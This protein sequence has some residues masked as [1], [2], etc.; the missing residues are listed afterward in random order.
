MAQHRVWT[1]AVQQVLD[2]AGDGLLDI[3]YTRRGSDVIPV[4]L[5]VS[6]LHSFLQHTVPHCSVLA[7]VV[8][9]QSYLAYDCYPCHNRAIRACTSMPALQHLHAALAYQVTYVE[10]RL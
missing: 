5:A 7:V 1:L 2:Q 8:E 9:I 4:Q 6:N 10:G 3:D